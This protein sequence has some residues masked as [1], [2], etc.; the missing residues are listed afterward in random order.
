MGARMIVSPASL[1]ARSA[2]AWADLA[3]ESW[4]VHCDLSRSYSDL[5][6]APVGDAYDEALELYQTSD[7]AREAVARAKGRLKWR[8]PPTPVAVADERGTQDELL[9]GEGTVEPSA[10]PTAGQAFE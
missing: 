7:A 1:P 3:W 10:P 9:P 4:A 2:L 6:I 5:A 8:R